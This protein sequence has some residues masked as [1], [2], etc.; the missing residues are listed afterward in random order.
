MVCRLDNFSVILDD[1]GFFEYFWVTGWCL[2]C[3]V[4]MG[5][6]YEVVLHKREGLVHRKIGWFRIVRNQRYDLRDFDRLIVDSTFHRSRYDSTQGR[7][8][9]Q[10]PKFKVDLAG[11][12]RLNIRVFN[13]LTEATRL[14]R[15]L[16]DYMGLPLA[17]E[18]EVRT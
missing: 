7:H 1:I 12:R 11:D 3:L 9:S 18:T 5:F 2:F 15:A 13:N 10:E 6:V 14:G 16:A 4:S 17:E 8:L